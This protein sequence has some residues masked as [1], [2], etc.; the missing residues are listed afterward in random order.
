MANTLQLEKFVEQELAAN[1]HSQATSKVSA[2]I[3]GVML[4]LNGGNRLELSLILSSVKSVWDRTVV[5]YDWPYVD[6]EVEK[7][8]ED[9]AWK[10]AEQ[11]ITQLVKRFAELDDQ[12][13]DGPFT[14]A[15]PG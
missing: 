9:M 13:D 4:F 6:G 10:L 5:A 2:V 3:R 11:G 15:A 8:L 14:A 7:W 1:S 12:V